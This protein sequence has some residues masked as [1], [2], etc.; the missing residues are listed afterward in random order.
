[1]DPINNE[2]QIRRKN[3]ISFERVNA[4]SFFKLNVIIKKK[5]NDP[6]IIK[7]KNSVL[8]FNGPSPPTEKHS[9]KINEVTQNFNNNINSD[10]FE[11]SE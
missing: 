11:E 1:L 4:N 7:N 2:S 6:N 8:Y 9:T 10:F 5:M 3:R